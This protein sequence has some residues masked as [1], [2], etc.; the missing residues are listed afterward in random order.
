VNES[1][2]VQEVRGQELL[3][4]GGYGPVQSLRGSVEYA[5]G[6]VGSHPR[7]SLAVEDRYGSGGEHSDQALREQAG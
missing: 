6:A 2:L 7:P 1:R 4:R 3:R 5:F